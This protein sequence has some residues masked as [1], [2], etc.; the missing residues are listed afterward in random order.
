MEPTWT[1]I[2]SAVGQIA[3]AIISLVGF[4]FV[5]LQIRQTNENLRQSNHTAIYSIN[6]E[7]YK[8]FAENS[9]LR[10]FFHDGVMPTEKD[11]NK[12]LSVSELFA[13]FFEFILVE[14]DSLAPEIR[15]P[16]LNYMKKIFANSPGFRIFIHKNKDQY[17]E[18]LLNLFANVAPSIPDQVATCEDVKTEKDFFEVDSIYQ[19]CFGKSS[20]P[21]DL[22]HSWWLKQPGGII[23]LKENQVTIGA[24][25]FWDISKKCFELL[26][27]GKIKEREIS[28]DDLTV[29]NSGYLYISEAAI[30]DDYRNKKLSFLLLRK[31]ILSI[32]EKF[33]QLKGKR[34]LQILAL[35]FSSEGEIILRKLGFQK[36]LD[37]TQTA[38]NQPLFHL[39]I[40]SMESVLEIKKALL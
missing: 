22:Q 36:I 20:V 23:A 29:E 32:E 35:G 39:K 6:T 3:S 4:I 9:T 40:E 30:K 37:A 17:C 5:Y 14:R 8:F 31:T 19:E 27:H 18:E 21:T 12:V 11:M 10:P 33:K 1:D 2:G 24:V 26:M 15:Q 25:S 13:D 28:A 7:L 34:N 16:W 38:D